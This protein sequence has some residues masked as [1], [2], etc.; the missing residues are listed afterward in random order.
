M[1]AADGQGRIKR[2]AKQHKAKRIKGKCLR[3]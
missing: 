3:V 2:Q 1:C